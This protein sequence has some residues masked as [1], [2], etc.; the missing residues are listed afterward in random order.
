[1]DWL[2]SWMS[3]SSLHTLCGY[4]I[5]FVIVKYVGDHLFNYVAGVFQ[6]HHRSTD[7]FIATLGTGVF[8]SILMTLLVGS[9]RAKKSTSATE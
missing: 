8:W 9:K 2:R 6:W 3:K 1:M 7:T 4:F 5:G